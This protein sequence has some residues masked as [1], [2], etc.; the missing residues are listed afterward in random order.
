M[1]GKS[2]AGAL[3]C[4]MYVHHMVNGLNVWHVK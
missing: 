2:A 3:G 4:G 1:N